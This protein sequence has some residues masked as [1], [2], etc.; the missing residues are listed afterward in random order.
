MNI[1]T[2]LASIQ[3]L[4]ET[5]L[6][7]IK[8]SRNNKEET[9]TNS[10][11]YN[12]L[13]TTINKNTRES[14]T[15]LEEISLSLKVIPVIEDSISSYNETLKMQGKNLKITIIEETEWLASKLSP[16]DE[17][18]EKSKTLEKEF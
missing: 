3:T 17:I 2:P 8:W 7:F 6:D 13:L 5:L 4:G 15:K 14:N 10:L 12:Q 9:S 1:E 18:L 11:I 16:L